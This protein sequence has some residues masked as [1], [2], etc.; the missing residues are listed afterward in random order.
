MA[1]IVGPE[2]F[3]ETALSSFLGSSTS[4]LE[5]LLS[6]RLEQTGEEGIHLRLKLAAGGGL[7]AHFGVPE[8][9]AVF[10]VEVFGQQPIL[11]RRPLR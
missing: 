10:A 2:L 11:E 3:G 4:G 6:G 8:L 7:D 9:R 5:A 1:L